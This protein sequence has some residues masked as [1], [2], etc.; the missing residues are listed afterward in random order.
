VSA[1]P[2]AAAPRAW[3]AWAAVCVI[4]GTTY[5]GIKI[6]LETMPPFLM[7]GLRYVLAGILLAAILAARGRP[8]P[9]RADWG[10]LAV[11]GFFM[12]FLGNGGVVL[13]EQVVP[14]G[15]TAV[16]IGTSPFW[17][18]SI[19]AM[20]TGGRQ[21][22]A[23]EWLGLTVG[24]AGIVLLVWPD[25]RAGGVGGRNFALGVLALQIACA[26]WAVGSAYTRRHVMPRDVMGSA[27]LQMLF[28]GLFMTVAG[29]LL[30]EWTRLAFNARTTTAF[31]YLVVVGAVIAF[32]AYSYALRHLDIAIVSL[33]SY[34]NPIIAVAL[35][36]LLL[37]EPFHV[38]MLIAAAVIV[39]GVV[40]VGPAKK[41]HHEETKA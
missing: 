14:S 4:W 27:A 26:G 20:V 21:M 29:T 9:A 34:I 28:G 1:S 12:L 41:P 2:A 40:I 16:L 39:V 38:R 36:T 24:F 32:A 18:V 19:D 15:L 11:L 8:L 6:A 7:G 33:Y 5:L 17:M 10:R 31:L 37:D 13:G 35:G 25:I 23:R 3:V 22:H 30:G